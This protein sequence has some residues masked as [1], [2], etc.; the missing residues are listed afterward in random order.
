MGGEPGHLFGTFSEPGTLAIGDPYSKPPAT[1]LPRHSGKQFA[2][3]I[4]KEGRSPEVYLDKQIRS[5]GEGAPYVDAWILDKRLSRIPGKPVSDK[6]FATLVGRRG[7]IS[8]GPGS[9]DGCLS[10]VPLDTDGSAAAR[11][12]NP[13]RRAADKLKNMYTTGPKTGGFGRP[14]RDRTLG[15]PPVYHSDVYNGG[16]LKEKGAAY[17]VFSQVGRDFMPDPVHEAQ[18]RRQQGSEKP[19]KPVGSCHKRLSMRDV[20]PYTTAARPAPDID[21]TLFSRG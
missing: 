13:P 16:R 6:P 8:C 18:F 15:E 3:V 2:I 5:L 17:C 7:N 12:S 9:T 1:K 21:F 14:W 4:G 10:N 11:R 20:N 19:F